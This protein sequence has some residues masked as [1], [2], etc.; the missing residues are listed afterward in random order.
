MTVR[1][2]LPL[3][4]SQKGQTPP[5]TAVIIIVYFLFF[6]DTVSPSP[7]GMAAGP[8]HSPYRDS[9][10]GI[11]LVLI[12]GGCFDMG[13]VLGDGYFAERPVHTVCVNDFFIGKYEV[14]RGEWRAVMGQEAPCPGNGERFPVGCV[15]YDDVQV[16]MA[17]LS[18][19][20]GKRFR[21]PT[22][23]EWEYACRSGGKKQRYAGFNEREGISRYANFCDVNCAYD[24]VTGDQDDGH[25]D[26][27]PVGSFLPNGLGL[28][29]MSGN[30]WEWVS[31]WFDE[32]YYTI[33][34]RDNPQGPAFGRTRVVRGGCW[35]NSPN[36]LRCSYRFG[37]DPSFRENDIGFRV[38]MEQ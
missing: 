7:F 21:L 2:A 26:V 31:D 11:E 18:R 36:Y 20:S 32:A 25:K 12:Q 3:T 10:T 4:V 19:R 38:V 9:V 17:Q 29:D 24:W 35:L 8:P 22:E 1:E 15:N 30:M 5:I 23:A 16:F 37:F 14:T 13:D 34:A 6:C 28:F 27:A 33:S